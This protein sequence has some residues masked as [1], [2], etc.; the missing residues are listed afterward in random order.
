MQGQHKIT[1]VFFHPLFSIYIRPF[2]H[3]YQ[4]T[5]SKV[6]EI[7]INFSVGVSLSFQAIKYSTHNAER[8]IAARS[9]TRC[10]FQSILKSE[11][12]VFNFFNCPN[13]ISPFTPNSTHTSPHTCFAHMYIAKVVLRHR[14]YELKFVHKQ[15]FRKSQNYLDD[16]A[17]ATSTH[18]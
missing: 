16:F 7:G 18:L 13:P 9:S 12:N 3:D 14:K 17:L 11:Q 1:T 2:S 6:K 4:K 10:H 5:T 15:D 8:G